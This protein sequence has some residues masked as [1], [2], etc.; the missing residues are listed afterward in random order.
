MTLKY[1]SGEE[2]I[3]GDRV[4]FHRGP[5]Q[6]E[7]VADALDNSETDWYVKEYGGGVMIMDAVAGRTFIP[8]DQIDE[9][10]D[11]EFVARLDAA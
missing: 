2:I 5:G 3:K 1:L 4:L 9:Y 7:L 6:V 11:L 8:A 10:E